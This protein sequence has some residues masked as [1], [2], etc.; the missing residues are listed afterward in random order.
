MMIKGSF[1]YR[2]RRPAKSQRR[3]IDVYIS[4]VALKFGGRLGKEGAETPNKYQSNRNFLINLTGS[5]FSE[6]LWLK[7]W[8]ILKM[9]SVCCHYVICVFLWKAAASTEG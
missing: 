7:S 2:I 3:E 1:Q 6:I 8:L 9:V 4:S 5:R